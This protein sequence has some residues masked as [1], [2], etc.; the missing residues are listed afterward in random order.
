MGVPLDPITTGMLSS[1][2]YDALKQGSKFVAS[3]FWGFIVETADEL[4]EKYPGVK[5][6]IIK[7][8]FF[9]EKTAKQIHEY[10][11]QGIKIDFEKLV[12]IFEQICKKHSLTINYK[13]TLRDFFNYLESKLVSKPKVHEKIKLNYLQDI[14]KKTDKILDQTSTLL[15]GQEELKSILEQQEQ[16]KKNEIKL[17]PKPKHFKGEIRNFI[18]REKEIENLISKAKI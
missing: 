2:A 16:A 18:G 1:A 15:Q 14:N 5:I 7:E 12:L 13:E 17:E 8:F 4:D 11:T 9:E 10:R 3:G 6:D